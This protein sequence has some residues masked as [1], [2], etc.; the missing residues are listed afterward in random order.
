MFDELWTPNGYG[1]IEFGLRV[2]KNGYS[3]LFTP[4]ATLYHHESPSRGRSVEF[5]EKASWR[6]SSVLSFY[7]ISL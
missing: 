5:F 4:Y 6:K 7:G 1:D 2:M 3:N